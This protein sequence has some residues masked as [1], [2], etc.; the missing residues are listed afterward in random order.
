[1]ANCTNYL[2]CCPAVKKSLSH[3]N[4]RCPHRALFDMRQD[5]ECERRVHVLP[6]SLGFDQPLPELFFARSS[7]ISKSCGARMAFF[8]NSDA[9]RWA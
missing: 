9:A 5:V 2:E 7:A 8:G 6:C 1:M 3:E 4:A